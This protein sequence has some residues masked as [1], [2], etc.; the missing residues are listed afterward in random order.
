MSIQKKT[1]VVRLFAVTAV[2][3]LVLL[4]A[5]AKPELQEPLLPTAPTA[6]LRAHY[7]I[8]IK[9]LPTIRGDQVVFAREDRRAL[10]RG[11]SYPKDA[12]PALYDES[13]KTVDIARLDKNLQWHLDPKRKRYEECPLKGCGTNLFN[14]TG[15]PPEGEESDGAEAPPPS[16]VLST[17]ENSFKVKETGQW[18][19]V[20]GFY[21]QEYV[22][23]WRMVT[24]DKQKRK[25]VMELT[26]TYWNTA[27]TPAIRDVWRVNEVFSRAYYKNVADGSLF[28]QLLPLGQYLDIGAMVGQFGPQLNGLSKQS[29][30][31]REISKLKGYPV[32]IRTVLTSDSK[33]CPE[34]RKS[35]EAPK[36][37]SKGISFSGGLSGLKASAESFI[38]GT[39]D[40]IAK[41]KAQ[42]SMEAKNAGKPIIDYLYEIYAVGIE[43]VPDNAF[44]PGPQYQI[45]TRR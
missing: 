6:T 27:E 5:C 10:G 9:A 4:S 28:A 31:Q 17:V 13:T 30:F 43:Q 45:V 25:D 8:N 11:N 7:T 23:T 19:N 39:A 18:R 40:K 20:N 35:A 2:S 12:L 44:Q 38:K 3:A 24:Q 36:E 41:D 21:S 15:V 26:L 22:A 37:E 1:A 32:S 29:D 14:M 34:E 33:S 42:K 16:C